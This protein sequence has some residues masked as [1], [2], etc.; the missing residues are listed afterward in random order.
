MRKSVIGFMLYIFTFSVNAA[1]VDMGKITY[2]SDTNLEWL[3]VNE[4]VGTSYSDVLTSVYVMQEGF[5]YATEAELIVLYDNAGG[6]GVY[7]NSN[8]HP[9][10]TNFDAAELLIEL[11]G[12]TS[13]TIN[14]P[15]DQV[16]EDFH[17]AMFG[18]E[19]IGGLQ[20]ASLVDAFYPPD[21]RSGEGAIW[22]NYADT[23][24][25][26]TEFWT[27]YLVRVAPVP[28]PA[29]VWLFGSG[30]IGLIAFAKRR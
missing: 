10:A 9:I 16:N 1:L 15:C 25:V 6:G 28:I 2:D 30:L 24:P 22:L 17:I 13:Y 29:A 3:D 4:T 14:K 18:P 20:T 21:S 8:G 27:S 19:V 7:Y 5:R 26:L 11:M 12:C 23:N